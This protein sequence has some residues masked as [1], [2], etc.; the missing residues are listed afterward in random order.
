MAAPPWLFPADPVRTL[1]AV[2]RSLRH[3][4]D[5]RFAT[6]GTL[7]CRLSRE[8]R[9][10][11]AGLVD[12]AELVAPL[13]NGGLPPECDDLLAEL[14]LEDTTQLHQTAAYAANARSLP[15][16]QVAA[17]LTAEHALRWDTT[18][19]PAG[20]DLLRA[21]SLWAGTEP[22]PLATTFWRQ[23]WI[24]MFC[25]WEL[26]LRVDGDLTRWQ[27][28]EVDLDVAEGA[29]P[30]PGQSVEPVVTSGRV[31]LTSAAARTF[32]TQVAGFVS[33]ETQRG[34]GLAALYG[35]QAALSSVAAAGARY[36]LLTRGLPGLREELLGLA[37]ADAGRV[38]VNTAGT[39]TPPAPVA[40]PV[41]LRGGVASFTRLRIIDAFG[42]TIEIPPATITGAAV[43]ERLQPPVGTSEEKRPAAHAAPPP[44]APVPARA[45]LRRPGCTGHGGTRAGD[46]RPG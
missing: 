33:A 5:G 37:W 15:V 2:N 29:S 39:R 40:L 9:T 43:A 45:H 10:Q 26:T 11:F 42:R 36:D 3:G 46:R 31:L 23:P 18:A 14:V 19:D 41:L 12:G 4:Y 16:E 30:D 35:Q 20:K 44:D 22:S 34:P 17:R 28:T 8:E 6:D 13:G 32:A 25:E 38:A 21:A 24:P 27:L 1:R 7:A